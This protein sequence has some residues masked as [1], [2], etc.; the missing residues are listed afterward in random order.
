MSIPIM[1]PVR[2]SNVSSIGYVAE[3]R[4]LYVAFNSDSLYRHDNVAI[5][6]YQDFMSAPSK[7]RFVAYRLKGKYPYKKIR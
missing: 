2:S 7:G 4:C 3:T 6:T 5:R 1:E